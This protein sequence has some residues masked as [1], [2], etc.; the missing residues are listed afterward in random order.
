MI[1]NGFEYHSPTSLDQAVALMKKY[2]E[3]AKLLSG[4]HS[5]IPLMKLR[6]AEP[7]V[8]VDLN[9][10]PGLDYLKEEGGMLKIGALVR[11]ADLEVSPVVKAKFPLIIDAAKL[12]ADPSVRNRAT[13]CGN[14]AHGDPANDH[15]AVMLALGASVVLQGSGKERVLPVTEFF[16]DTLTTALKHDEILKEIRVPIPPAN[17]AGAYFKL[18]RRVGDFAI[19][20]VGAQV[21]LDKSGKIASAGIGLTNAGPVPIKAVQA[22][23]FLAGKEPSEA[24][25]AEAGKLAEAAS[26][27]ASDTRAPSDYKKAMVKELTIRCL[28]KATERAKG[29]K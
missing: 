7:A 18:E 25:F 13:V 11:E 29:G 17:S 28:R 6:F 3:D 10:I 8:I 5:L 26:D 15:P 20:A 4:G 24:N 21:T 22:E 27:P 23:K 12:I 9:A 14:L 16:L 1:P 19:V 2:G